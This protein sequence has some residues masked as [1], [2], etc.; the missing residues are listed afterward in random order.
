MKLNKTKVRYIL[1]QNRKGVATEE[2]ALDVK[3][4]QRRVQQIIKEYNE[5]GQE[6]VLGEKVGRPRKPYIEKEAEVIRA[7]HA[8]YR[9]GAR[10]L[11]TVIRKQFK[12]CISHNRIHMYL[13][14]DGLAQEDLKKQ[15]RRKW[16]RYERKHSLSAG[17][18]DWHEWDGTDVKVCVILDDASRMVLAGG[19]FT[20]INTENSMLI[21][22]QLVDKFWWLCPMRE[23][24]LDHGSEFGAHRIHDDGS[25][26]SEF[27]D[28]LKKYGIKPILARVKHPQT[29]GK[30]ERFFGEYVKHRSVF[31]S[32][33]E[34][35]TWYNDRPHGSLN[36]QSLE[37]PERA[38][39]RKMPLEAYFAIGHRL[40][41]LWYVFSS[42]LSSAK[43]AQ[44]SI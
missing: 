6:P 27:K 25:W 26:N 32:F 4:S 20:E 40:F 2:I 12:I 11:E 36:F 19:E 22:D 39:R 13:K 33:D 7:A 44:K 24:I 43:F 41:G 42:V 34:F 35:I 21:I 30:L 31:H 29:N 3:V 18:I 1:R 23:L 16:V 38:F 8:R 15:K 14:A 10:M 17:H 28:H 9:F 37:T 5:T